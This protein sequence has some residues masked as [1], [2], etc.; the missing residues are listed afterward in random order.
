LFEKASRGLEFHGE[1]RLK[2]RD[3]LES[4]DGSGS[5]A[6]FAKMIELLSVLSRSEDAQIL[7]SEA[8]SIGD[9]IK[10]LSDHR[11]IELALDYVQRNFLDAPSLEEVA[12]VVGMSGTTFSRFFKRKTGN[13]FSE[14]ISSLR[15]WMACKLLLETDSPITEICFESGFNNIANFN[16]TFLRKT[17]MTP[18]KYRRVSRQRNMPQIQEKDLRLNSAL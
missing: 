8:F 4:M 3:I 13:T 5:L 14:H 7:S 16:R 11:Q 12:K 6:D 15:L 17:G 9:R 10:G 18:S 1:A 2:G